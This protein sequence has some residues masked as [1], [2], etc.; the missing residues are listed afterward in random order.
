MDGNTVTASDYCACAAVIL[1][2][3]MNGVPERLSSRCFSCVAIRL[4]KKYLHQNKLIVNNVF[5]GPRATAGHQ[6][7]SGI[8]EKFY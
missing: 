3:T 6:K 5:G 8:L 4:T 2:F 1:T 7:Y